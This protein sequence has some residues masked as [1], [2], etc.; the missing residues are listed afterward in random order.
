MH[1]FLVKSGG[2]VEFIFA[3]SHKIAAVNFA[4]NNKAGP[5]I[6]VLCQDHPDE[7][8]YF[9]TEALPKIKVV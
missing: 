4:K 8:V 9:S 5:I 3:L 2:M 1:K 7:E 6:S